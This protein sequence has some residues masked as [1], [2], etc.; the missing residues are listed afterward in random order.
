MA[1]SSKLIV[2]LQDFHGFPD[3][4]NSLIP[5]Y[6]LALRPAKSKSLIVSYGVPLLTEFY[7]A[8]IWFDF[9]RFIYLN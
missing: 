5:N 6:S 2:I 1:I 3:L 8:E 7:I 4:F 9:P